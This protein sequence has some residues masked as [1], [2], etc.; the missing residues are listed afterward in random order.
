[1]GGCVIISTE[2]APISSVNNNGH[3]ALFKAI[4]LDY[5]LNIILGREAAD[6]ILIIPTDYTIIYYDNND[7]ENIFDY[8]KQLLCSIMERFSGGRKEDNM[9]GYSYRKYIYFSCSK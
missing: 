5:F 9:N 2:N 4:I 1:M 3:K 7:R 8:L 6:V